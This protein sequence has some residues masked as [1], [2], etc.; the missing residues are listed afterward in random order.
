L[1]DIAT[2]AATSNALYYF[3]NNEYDLSGATVAFYVENP[4]RLR[5][6][7][8]RLTNTS[9]LNSYFCWVRSAGRKVDIEATNVSIPFGKTFINASMGAAGDS[10]K[11][12]ISRSDLS[13][14]VIVFTSAT[15]SNVYKDSLVIQ[16]STIPANSYGEQR[17]K[18]Y[19]Q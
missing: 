10:A 7:N 1:F 15:Q 5:F 4:S 12:K 11:L 17:R 9:S 14:T 18:L 8:D 19:H 13:G 3:K 2:D 6:N 16:S